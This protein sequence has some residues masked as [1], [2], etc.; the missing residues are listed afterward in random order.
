MILLHFPLPDWFVLGFYFVLLA[1]SFYV[2]AWLEKAE[3]NR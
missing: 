2:G 3:K 1:A